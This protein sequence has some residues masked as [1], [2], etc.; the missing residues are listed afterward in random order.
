MAVLLLAALLAA[1]TAWSATLWLQPKLVAARSAHRQKRDRVLLM[2]RYRLRAWVALIEPYCRGP[3]S[4][5][6]EDQLYAAG[7]PWG[8]T[9][10]SEYL[11][12]GVIGIAGSVIVGLFL[13]LLLGGVGFGIFFA[14][15]LALPIGA[16][17]Y[18]SIGSIIKRRREMTWREFPFF[19]DTL[20]MTM[21]GG[22]TLAQAIEIYVR[23]NPQS[24]FAADLSNAVNRS[25]AGTDMIEALEET[26]D[27]I[28]VNEIKQTMQNIL[29]AEIE[30][31]DRLHL[32][33]ENADDMRARRWEESEKLTEILKTKIVLPTMMI[34]M[35]VMLL[36]LAPAFVEVGNS[37]LF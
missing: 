4:K 5:R 6:L 13:G 35:S 7:S 12:L 29:T 25:Q 18:L 14:L 1:F 24:L 37:G 36:I 26:L 16:V 8:G 19:L 31:A 27:R 32:M 9:S 15:L 33:R 21:E 23:S 30:G 10:G 3:F 22:A 20:V 11:A 28:N 34:F 17:W 2:D